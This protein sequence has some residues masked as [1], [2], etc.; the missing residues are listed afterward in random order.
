MQKVTFDS[1]VFQ[2]IVRPDKFPNDGEVTAL[3]AIHDALKAGKLVGFVAETQADLEAIKRNNRPAYFSGVKTDVNFTETDQP[4]GVIKLSMSIGPKENAHPG[5]HPILA[6]RFTDALALGILFMRCPRIGLPRPIELQENWFAPE[7]DDAARTRRH[8]TFCSALRAIEGKGVGRAKVKQLG[9][10]LA[11]KHGKNVPWFEGLGLASTPQEQKQ[12][13]DGVGEW[14][15]GDAVAA[16]IG[17]ENDL[18]CTR[19]KGVSAG[20]S[21]LNTP[22]RDWLSSAYGIEFVTPAEL[23]ARL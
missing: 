13:A 8:D 5:L 17:Y 10:D 15:D 19:D 1:N 9:D 20:T 16:H 22:N 11:R 14:A 3:Q 12:V 23:A 4:S 2:P 6:D 18:F 7:A 21:I